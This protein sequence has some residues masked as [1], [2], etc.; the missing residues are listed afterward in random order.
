MPR[1]TIPD[2]TQPEAPAGCL[3]RHKPPAVGSD[4]AKARRVRR[5]S[6]GSRGCVTKFLSIPALALLAIFL[7]GADTPG[8]AEDACSTSKA[9]EEAPETF[10]A[11][12]KA[13]GDKGAQ[14]QFDYSGEAFANLWGGVKRGGDYEGLA[15]ISLKLDLQKL[16]QWN[17]ATLYASMLYPHGNGITAQYVHDYNLLSNIDAY[18][19]VRLF[20]LWLQQAFCDGRFSIRVGHLTTDNDFFVSNNSAL[21]INSVFGPLGTVFHDVTLPTYPVASDGVRLHYDFNPSLYVQALAADDNPGFQNINDRSGTRFG[22]NRSDG[23]LAFYEAGY[24]PAPPNSGSPLSATYKLGGWFDSQFHP[25]ISAASS[26]HGDYGFY[27]VADQPLYLAPGCAKDSPQ[28]LSAFGRVSYAPDQRNAVV[29][30]FDTGFNYTGL[31]PGRPKDLLGIAFSFERLGTDL[32]PPS[33]TPALSHH[34]HVLEFTYLANL[35]DLFSVQPDIQYIINPG[36]IGKIPNALVAGIRFN[37][38]F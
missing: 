16:V 15:K 30:Y 37:L 13:L 25:D 11:E 18:D 10:E 31:F 21:F 2:S 4:L 23:L 38:A 8:R 29:Y 14:F 28:G 36:G 22:F 12:I 35:T 6:A 19:S 27:A 17:G 34:E 33:A 26:A 5:K 7:H 9:L 1:S 24:A 32:Q 3:P 20:E